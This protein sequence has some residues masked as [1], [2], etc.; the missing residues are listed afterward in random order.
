MRW[1]TTLAVHRAHRRQCC[2]TDGTLFTDRTDCLF[3]QRARV[4][5]P[6]SVTWSEPAAVVAVVAR[7]GRNSSASTIPATASPTLTQSIES[8]P[9]TKADR[10]DA[11]SAVDPA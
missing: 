7:H 8:M 11:N 6:P 2:F 10:T 4:R 9:C 1:E 5:M 3:R